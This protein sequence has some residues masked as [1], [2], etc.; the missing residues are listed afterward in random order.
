MSRFEQYTLEAVHPLD[1]EALPHAAGISRS[2]SE[3]GFVGTHPKG[4]IPLDL[5]A[6]I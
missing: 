5:E 2:D 6:P 1:L 4:G 3:H